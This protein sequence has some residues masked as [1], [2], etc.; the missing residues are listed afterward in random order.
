MKKT[1][2]ELLRFYVDTSVLVAAHTREPHTA[3]AQAWLAAQGGGRLLLSMW[4]L[5]E[6]DSALAI[7]RRRGELTAAAHAAA[8]KEIDAFSRHFAPLTV[9]TEGDH[10]RARELCRH[11]VSKLRAGD[12]LHLAIALRLGAKGFATLDDVLAS[13]AS[14]HGLVMMSA[15]SC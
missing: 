8:V 3:V 14:A 5:L 2:T 10:Q 9:P 4:T 12:A 7:K 15:M 1:G 6:C 13:N 11:A